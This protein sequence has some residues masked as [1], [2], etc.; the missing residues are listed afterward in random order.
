MAQKQIS[1]TSSDV[2][3]LGST[4]DIY[5]DHEKQY[6]NDVWRTVRQMKDNF[7]RPK[8]EFNNLNYFQWDEDNYLKSINY[9]PPATKVGEVQLSSGLAAEKSSFV[10]SML[11]SFNFKTVA[12][13]FNKDDDFMKELSTVITDL[14]EKVDILEKWDDNR[15]ET[16]QGM[17]DRGTYYTMQAVEFP[18]YATKSKINPKDIG[19][20]SVEWFDNGKKGDVVLRTQPFNPRMVLFPNMKERRIQKQPAIAF[21]QVLSEE[22]ARSKYGNWDR[23][24]D[25]PLRTT[26]ATA[27]SDVA[28]E[29]ELYRDHYAISDNLVEGDVEEVVYM[30]S[31]PYGNEVNIY[32]NGIQMLPVKL[33][34]KNKQQNRYVVSGFPLTAV[35][36][37]GL[38]PL[39]KWDFQI[40]PNF[41]IAK[42]TISKTFYDQDVLDTWIKIIYKK[43]LRSTNP[44]LGN[45]SGQ[46]ITADMIQPN[47]IVNG[48]RKDDIFS[49]LPQELVQGVTSGEFSF[50]EFMKKSMEE[51]TFSAQFM[52]DERGKGV[53]ATAYLEN[54][55]AQMLKFSAL[56][57][58]VIRGE[59]DRAELILK[60]GIIPHFL[61]KNTA[62][63]RADNLGPNLVDIYK[64]F[65]ISKNDE[66]GSYD[67]VISVFDSQNIKASIED[68]QFEILN[69]EQEIQKKTG[70]RSKFFYIDPT[71]INWMDMLIYWTSKPSEKDSDNI[72][73]MMFMQTVQ[74]A[75][76][77]FGINPA[78]NEKL[79]KRWSQV[80][81]ED[82]DTFFPD[83]EDVMAAQQALGADTGGMNPASMTP[84]NAMSPERGQ[85]ESAVNFQ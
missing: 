80:F 42:G 14:K 85:M 47:T 68:V 55:K 35:S 72:D 64:R 16:Y 4:L 63:K 40:V 25:V 61:T 50:F 76:Q 17:S 69:K 30:K 74:A 46:T 6:I 41:A 58:G 83:Q 37:S 38:Y 23:W 7:T 9:T 32:L 1:R 71:V 28:S 44:T 53:T 43:A 27:G 79:K 51:K 73:K 75:M 22:D 19:K 8:V 48:I 11:K 65:S 45:R 26:R 54:K 31:L 24:N 49:I 2:K 3:Q 33:V 82:Y 77:I 12:K 81:A 60:N 39:V 62:D 57:D 34:N 10:V 52:G 59:T 70:K 29:F 67:S 18:Y 15:I 66:D 13:A 21:A 20:K 84:P 36:P 5:E 78:S 56:I